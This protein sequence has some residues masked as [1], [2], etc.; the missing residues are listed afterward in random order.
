MQMVSLQTYFN[1]LFNQRQSKEQSYYINKHETKIWKN[2]NN[3]ET[4]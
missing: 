2:N 3:N 1:K 4:S